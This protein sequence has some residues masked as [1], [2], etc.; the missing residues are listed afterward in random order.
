MKSAKSGVTFKSD[1]NKKLQASDKV[2]VSSQRIDKKRIDT[3]LKI[4][5]VPLQSE[6][7]TK[8]IKGETDKQQ[9]VIRSSLS[10]KLPDSSVIDF[11]NAKSKSTAVI[12]DSRK[13]LKPINKNVP[14]K[15]STAPVLNVKIDG[16]SLYNICMT[17][18][19]MGE[20]TI[21]VTNEQ[22]LGAVRA[23]DLQQWHLKKLKRRFIEIDVDSSGTIDQGEFMVSSNIYHD[24]V[25]MIWDKK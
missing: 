2:Y 16:D 23:L 19:G 25:V 9:K 21:S 4:L 5:G 3:N 1:V 12:L 18:L 6:R 24:Q 10:T 15:D 8:K 11:A 7:P 20:E 14:L 22:S 17:M 13:K